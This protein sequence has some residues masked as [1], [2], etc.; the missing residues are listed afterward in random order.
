MIELYRKHYADLRF[1]RGGLFALVKQTFGSNDALYPGCFVHITPSLYIPHV[2]Y[3]DRHPEAQAFFADLESIS[4]FVER[5][6]HY[7]RSA[8]IRFIAEDFNK[9]L[10]IPLAGIDLLISI[11]AAGVARACWQY[12]RP[13]GVLLINNLTEVDTAYYQLHS[14]IRYQR[15][16]YRLLEGDHAAQLAARKGTN[17]VLNYLCQGSQGIQYAESETYFIFLKRRLLKR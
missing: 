2:I 11:F 16:N 3:V 14:A 13:G 12:L 5:N 17:R 8:Y 6:K 9:P 15:G 7:K 4:Q 10:P 1:E